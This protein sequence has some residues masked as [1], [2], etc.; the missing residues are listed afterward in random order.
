MDSQ[1][2][3]GDG[4]LFSESVVRSYVD[5]PHFVERRWLVERVES[6]LADPDCRFL[7]LTAEPGAGKS[8]F[9]AGLA[10]HH[11]EWP[12]YFIRRDQLSPLGSPGAR[13]F[14]LQ[15][16]LQLAAHHPRIFAT[17]SITI[18]IQQRLGAVTQEASVI[19]A[20]I[21][22]LIGSPFRK[23]AL[24]IIQEVERT[25]GNVAGLRVGEWIT[26][27]HLIPLADLQSLALL[28]P[29]ATLQ[30]EAPEERIV[31]LIDA[32]DE[33][34]YQDPDG[35]LLAWLETCPKL[36]ANVRFVLTSRPEELLNVFRQRQQ[37]WLREE[38]IDAHAV[39]VQADLRRY[40]LTFIS[41]EVV[42]R[43]LAGRRIAPGELVAQA[44][45]KA[46]GN[47]Q[48]LAALF[49]GIEQAVSAG[50]QEHL[51]QLLQLQDIPA[52]LGELYAF[53]LELIKRSIAGQAVEV[54][55]PTPFEIASLPAWEGLY[56]PLLGVLAVAREPLARSQMRGFAGVQ[57][58]ERWLS[59]AIDRLGQFLDRVDGRYRLY[60]STFPEFLTSPE[61]QI[62]HPDV[63]LAPSEWHRK[64][65]GHYRGRAPSW[66]A[67]EWSRVDDYGLRHLA[68]HLS[69]LCHEDRFQRELYGLICQSFMRAKHARYGSHQP[70]AAD[71]A[72]AIEA[73]RAAVPPNLVQEVRGRLIYATLR[74][75]ATNVSP[76]ALRVLALVGQAV[77]AQGLAALM[78]NT[79]LQSTGYRL[80]GEVLLE[81]G[82]PDE[83]RDALQ[84]ALAAAQAMEEATWSVDSKVDALSA[85]APA[86]AQV[87]ELDRLLTAVEALGKGSLLE[88][89]ARRSRVGALSRIAM[90]LAEADANEEAAGVAN[91]ALRI[92]DGI[93][94]P[95]TKAQALSRVAEVIERTG[96]RAGATA[97]ADRALATAEAMSSGW[98]KAQALSTAAQALGRVAAFDRAMVVTRMVGDERA[99][100]N[101]LREIALAS[102][103]ARDF[104]RALAAAR[105]I[106]D[107]ETKAEVLGRVA[108][109]VRWSD[110]E[111]QA[112]EVA[113]EALT[114][115]RT[116]ADDATRWRALSQV[117]EVL[118]AVEGVDR[119]L[120]VV[121]TLADEGT[122]ADALSRVAETLSWSNEKAPAAAVAERA[123]SAS[124]AM[125]EAYARADA[126]SRVARVLTQAGDTDR[127]LA[128]VEGIGDR[129]ITDRVLST[130]SQTLA[131]G[132]H[133]ERAV[134]VAERICDE[135]Q[136]GDM[137]ARIAELLARAGESGRA[138]EVVSR[139]LAAGETVSGEEML[140]SALGAI[141]RVLDGAG[142][143]DRA[144]V[145]A[146][147]MLAAAEPIT[148]E[149][150]KTEAL[151]GVA[152]V[153]AL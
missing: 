86:L 55:G 130:I 16:G 28:D 46:E 137:L 105:S 108:S 140:V 146:N 113:S 129:T 57:V 49:R 45:T 103:Q 66:D 97:L 136:R 78:P 5:G 96:E 82:K 99:R 117:V 81:R 98:N 52:G 141:A 85:L 109:A 58:E 93:T 126:L 145:V 112:P 27:P 35:S 95:E 14:L 152:G 11:P 139:A 91:R 120:E 47:F 115:A 144:V 4:D 135:W 106:G 1:R 73:A 125:S 147:R 42:G 44:V 107:A 37:N 20:E 143:K 15:T 21:R 104:D 68:A 131:Q 132:G 90:A 41:K 17:E 40:A 65:A 12:R 13:A 39:P 50:E 51:S 3:W 121:E 25:E 18:T 88:E 32:L 128:A 8:A 149:R 72:L 124:G 151:N 43:A 114:A 123:L 110:D 77:R 10:R 69:A 7:L 53:F 122:K 142:N 148:D 116:I 83:A 71:V 56:Q 22:R 29:A 75:L 70:F 79:A 87:G 84:Q 64:I 134:T 94:D 127:V 153:L 74:R 19:G 33:L 26:D 76:T 60:H 119:A 62:A 101:A 111:E 38:T 30:R 48:Y 63:Y 61:T 138:M 89:A 34:R 6:A 67:V 80:I 59:G 2:T 24:E 102:I 54:P 31:I 150:A 133:V 92:T 23:A 118:T 36:P 9:L 100:S